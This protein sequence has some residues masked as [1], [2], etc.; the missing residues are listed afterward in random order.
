M[1]KTSK[2]TL[3]K[4]EQ[5]S[6]RLSLLRMWFIKNLTVFLWL[7]FIICVGLTFSGLIG[8]DTP[9]LGII[10]GS[11]SDDIQG[12]FNNNE[13][14][15]TFYGISESIIC[16]VIAVALCAKKMKALS[17]DDIKSTKHKLLMVKAGLWFNE[18]GKLTKRVETITKTDI[19]K[20]GYI[21]EKKAEEIQK[22]ENIVEGLK[23]AGEEFVTIVTLDLSEVQ[24][25]E[26]EEV[27]STTGLNEIKDGID[28]ISNEIKKDTKKLFGQAEEEIKTKDKESLFS[29]VKNFFKDIKTALAVTTKTEEE[30]KAEEKAKIAKKEAAEKAKAEKEA[31]KART[32]EE[33]VEAK[34]EEKVIKQVKTEKVS[35]KKDIVVEEKIDEEVKP[36]TPASANAQLSALLKNRK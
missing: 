14:W 34:I 2:N 15:S 12:I 35:I 11:L 18:D 31:A 16:L 29:G 3:T 17:F 25:E 8:K 32:K 27:Y 33:K 24:K 13:G 6:L 20:D 5:F 30:K 26:K 1:S 28:E 7:A 4:I 36:T 10:F 23:R 19:D 21:G 9:V 22:E